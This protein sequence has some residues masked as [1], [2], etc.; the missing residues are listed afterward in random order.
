[1]IY[2]SLDH[3][4]RAVNRRSGQLAWQ[5]RAEGRPAFGPF[6]LKAGL[7]FAESGGTRLLVLSTD[8][9]KKIW[10]WDLPSGAILQ[11]PALSDGFAVVLAWGEASVPT[12]YRVALPK[13]KTQ[14]EAK[15]AAKR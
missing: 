15:A 9:G 14:A 7:L 5:Y 1:M 2:G 13:P 11:S 3:F 8:K 12:L 6:P 10:E 4:I